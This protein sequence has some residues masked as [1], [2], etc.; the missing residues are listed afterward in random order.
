MRHR[1]KKLLLEGGDT[2]HAFLMN[3]TNAVGTPH[4][5]ERKHILGGVDTAHHLQKKLS[6]GLVGGEWVGGPN[7][8]IMPLCGSILQAGTYQILSLAENPRW[9]RVWQKKSGA[10][11]IS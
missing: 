1:T 9:S 6:C 7:Q 10:D 5:I 8:R 3:G 11:T 4:N 2:A